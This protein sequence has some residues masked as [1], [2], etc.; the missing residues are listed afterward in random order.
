MLVVYVCWVV[1]PAKVEMVLL[2]PALLPAQRGLV[3]FRGG[4]GGGRCPNLGDETRRNSL[5]QLLPVITDGQPTAKPELA[6]GD[7]V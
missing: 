7:G 3:L 1:G 5:K 2:R 6:S 4:G